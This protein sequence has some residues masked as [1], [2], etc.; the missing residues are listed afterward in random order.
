MIRTLAFERSLLILD[1]P[2]NHLDF[3]SRA[4]FV[5]F[6]IQL[7]ETHER[8]P[9]SYMPTIIIISHDNALA[10]VADQ[11]IVMVP[12]E[13]DRVLSATKLEKRYWGA[14]AGYI[15]KHRVPETEFVRAAEAVVKTRKAMETKLADLNIPDRLWTQVCDM[16]TQQEVYESS[17]T[18]AAKNFM[19][20]RITSK[21]FR[22]RL[23]P[24]LMRIIVRRIM[25]QGL[26]KSNLRHFVLFGLS[27]MADEKKWHPIAQA[28]AMEQNQ[29]TFHVH[30]RLTV[31]VQCVR[32]IKE[33]KI[34][35]PEDKKAQL[36][37]ELLSTCKSE[38]EWLAAV[39]KKLGRDKPTGPRTAAEDVPDLMTGTAPPSAATT[40]AAP[41]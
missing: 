24:W 14:I 18:D 7:K 31:C 37:A 33:Q 41:S 4:W 28:V 22:A 35:M 1:E 10:D 23:P 12:P 9:T 25:D 8:D 13:V 20:K 34:D 2:L 38:K 3:I 27:A 40:A 15:H 19:E 16:L 6:L 29:V 17:W 5:N 11:I 21:L 30:V 32:F 26:Q 36:V 39:N